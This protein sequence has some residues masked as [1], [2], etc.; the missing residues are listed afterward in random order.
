MTGA[1]HS[2]RSAIPAFALSDATAALLDKEVTKLMVEA[3]ERSR[4][5]IKANRKQ[6]DD[7]AK[8]LLKEE[9]IDESVVTKVLK[10]A[11]LPAAVKLY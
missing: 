3:A 2:R 4:A 7:L 6:L 9:T 10:D 5:V 1:M 8:V 11:V